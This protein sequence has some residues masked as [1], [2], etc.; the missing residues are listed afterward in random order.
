MLGTSFYHP[1][2]TSRTF[3][4]HDLLQLT[5]PKLNRTGLSKRTHET[6]LKL[7][8]VDVA[9]SVHAM[10]E[11]AKNKRINVAQRFKW[12]WCTLIDACWFDRVSQTLLIS[13]KIASTFV[14][15]NSKNTLIYIWY[16]YT[17]LF[18]DYN[19]GLFDAHF[20]GVWVLGFLFWFCV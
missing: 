1:N 14:L 15:M 13:F 4:P 8:W 20:C 3:R 10:E 11:R 16:G 5:A 6:A 12:N 18:F 2:T 17:N 19:L 9:A 7:C